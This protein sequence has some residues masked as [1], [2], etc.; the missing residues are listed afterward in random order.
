MARAAL[1]LGV[2]DLAALAEVSPNTIGRLEQ[3][4]RLYPRT[5]Q[6]IRAVLEAAGVEFVAAGPY[7]GDGGPG[8]RLKATDG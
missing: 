7:Q 4:E 1:D 8:V 3:G 5:L 6:A 2:R